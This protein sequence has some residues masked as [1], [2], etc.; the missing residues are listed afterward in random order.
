MIEP[1]PLDLALEVQPAP[2]RVLLVEDAASTR[3]F[4][5]AVLE[6]VD[7]L[8]VVGEAGTGRAAITSARQLQPDVILLDLSL[9]DTDGAELLPHLIAAVPEARTVIL[10][11]NARLAGPDLVAAGAAGFITKGLAPSALLKELF[12][13]LAAP[14]AGAAPAPPAVRTDQPAPFASPGPVAPPR[15][16]PRSVVICDA[17]PETRRTV[18]ELLVGLD[19]HIVSEIVTTDDVVAALRSVVGSLRPDL[20]VLGSIA[21]APA[22]LVTGLARLAPDTSFIVYTTQR[23]DDTTTD[24]KVRHVT[25]PDLELLERSARDLLTGGR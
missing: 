1:S 24:E 6:S 3:R 23:L 20:V 8:V 21:G 17:R 11:N 19:I 7:S 15:S 12:A 22:D 14:P 18:S 10:S 9:P 13:V 2:L 5:L 16:G 4:L 25:P